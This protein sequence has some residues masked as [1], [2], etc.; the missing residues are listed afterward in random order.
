MAYHNRVTTTATSDGNSTSIAPAGLASGDVLEIT[1]T[2]AGAWINV[3][4]GA[5]SVQGADCIYL[6]ADTPPRILVSQATTLTAIR[7]AS[8]AVITVAVL[9]AHP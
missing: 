5:S 7:A 9:G 4:G 2:G 3:L 8:G 6:A 1:V